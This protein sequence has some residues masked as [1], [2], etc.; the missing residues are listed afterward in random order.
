VTF[1]DWLLTLPEEERDEAEERAAIREYDGR[2]R[3]DSA[4]RLTMKDWARR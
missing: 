3:R 4:E 2:M 1:K